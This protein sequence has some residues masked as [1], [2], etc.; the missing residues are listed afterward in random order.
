MTPLPGAPSP[1]DPVLAHPS[2][3]SPSSGCSLELRPVRATPEPHAATG[4]PGFV[5]AVKEPPPELRPPASFPST[6]LGGSRWAPLCSDV[7]EGDDVRVPAE[8]GGGGARAAS[9]VLKLG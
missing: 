7:G 9:Q 3:V 1:R 2:P 4:P 6:A 8:V 5:P